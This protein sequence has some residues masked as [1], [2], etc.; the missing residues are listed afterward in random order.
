MPKY[1][2]QAIRLSPRKTESLRKKLLDWYAA[3]RRDLP[4]RRTKDPYAVWVSEVMLQQT[5]VQT[6]IPYYLR[7]LEEFPTIQDLARADLEKLLRLWAGLGYYS[8]ARNLQLAAREIMRRHDG[9]FPCSH[10]DALSLPGI[11]RYTAGAILSIA[12]DLPCAV[13]DGNIMRV[14]SRLFKLQ[15][16]I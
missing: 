7:F 4:W 9:K 12:F 8:R 2:D 1:R 10:S 3:H 11:G 5:Q 16:D 6:V 14:L 13:L 15:G